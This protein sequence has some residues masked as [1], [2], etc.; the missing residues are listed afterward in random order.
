MSLRIVTF[1]ALHPVHGQNWDTTPMRAGTYNEEKR[2]AA[3]VAVLRDVIGERRPPGEVLFVALQEVAGTLL[4]R[5]TPAMNEMGGQVVSAQLGRMPKLKE[6]KRRAG[7][8]DAMPAENSEFLVIVLFGLPVTT[9]V[10]AKNYENDAGKGY[11]AVDVPSRSLLFVTTHLSYSHGRNMQ[12][13]ALSHLAALAHGR[14][15]EQCIVTGDYNCPATVAEQAFVAC[16]N[17]DLV[18]VRMIEAPTPTRTGTTGASDLVSAE[19]IDHV[20][21][22][23]AMASTLPPLRTAAV[24]V[25]DIDCGTVSDH[26]PVE[27]CFEW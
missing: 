8:G 4:A 11:L 17:T 19:T 20:A 10:L 27:V 15:L 14:G 13:R 23:T 9:Q 2:S 16:N 7:Y 3:I 24:R 18:T 26:R 25:Y 12:I 5:L 22:L 6:G 21:V 1:N